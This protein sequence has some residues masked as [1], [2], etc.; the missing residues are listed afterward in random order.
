MPTPSET[1]TATETELQDTM[2][3]AGQKRRILT[4]KGTDATDS[5]TTPATLRDGSPKDPA[6]SG[7]DAGWGR[8]NGNGKGWGHGPWSNAAPPKPKLAA[9]VKSYT[10]EEQREFVY[11]WLAANFPHSISSA[12]H[13]L[14]GTFGIAGTRYSPEAARRAADDMAGTAEKL[15]AVNWGGFFAKRTAKD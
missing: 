10:D 4:L 6:Y 14:M 12:A 13:A 8:H 1:T 9:V 2:T 5:A 3:M 7:K 15:G 11:G